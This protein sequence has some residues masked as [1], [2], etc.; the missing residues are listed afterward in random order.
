MTQDT[1]ELLMNRSRP[2]GQLSMPTVPNLSPKINAEDD[3][4]SWRTLAPDIMTPNLQETVDM[5]R[6]SMSFSK[7]QEMS[8]RPPAEVR[9][10]IQNKLWRPKD[11]EMRLPLSLIHI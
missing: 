2:Q 5:F 11:E 1:E 10:S 8:G 3:L 4:A 9:R 6:R 7:L